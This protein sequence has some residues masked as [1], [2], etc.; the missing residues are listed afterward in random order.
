MP[1]HPLIPFKAKFILSVETTLKKIFTNSEEVSLKE[2]FS[3]VADELGNVDIKRFIEYHCLSFNMYSE[4]KH[5]DFKYD[6]V[7]DVS[8]SN[9]LDNDERDYPLSFK[10]ESFEGEVLQIVDNKI[11]FANSEK[12]VYTFELN[13]NLKLIKI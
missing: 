6:Q 13:D 3:K 8:P 12:E 4:Q 11:T 9:L 2:K 5:L 7:F 1:V 10:V